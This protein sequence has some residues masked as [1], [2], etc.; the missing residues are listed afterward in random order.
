MKF[1]SSS[2][3]DLLSKIQQKK[4]KSLLIHGINHGLASTIT[5]EIIKRMNLIV[6]EYDA[7]NITAE[8]L[9]LIANT[10]NFFGQQELIKITGTRSTINKELQSCIDSNDFKH[11]VCFISDESLPPSGIRKFYENDSKLASIGCYY[12]NEDVIT[13]II[14]QYCKKNNKILEDE[15]LFYL[16]SHLKGDNQII[17]SELEKI[18]NYTFDKKEISKNDVIQ[19]VNADIL[20]SGDEMCI[21]FA[22][23]EPERFLEEVEKLKL[24]NTNEVLIIRALARY[25]LNIYIV[26]LKIEDGQNIDLA[27]KSLYPPIFFKYIND[28]KQIIRTYSAN[29][30]IQCLQHIQQAEIEFK[31][32]SKA[33]NLFTLYL[34]V[35]NLI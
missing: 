3:S 21:Y 30:V 34:K 31:T 1:F 35:H 8:K 17:K 7:K 19:T 28:F 23:K 26:N 27:I 10:S 20:A 12:E 33:F 25:Y 13:K 5:K 16:K 22:K 9:N 2:L 6:S 11:F 14:L 29:D 24:Q 32:N 15:A 18:F 4:I